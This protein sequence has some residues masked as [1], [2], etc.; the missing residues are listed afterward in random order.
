MH[1]KYDYIKKSN[2][3]VYCNTIRGRFQSDHDYFRFYDNNNKI[4]TYILSIKL[5][6]KGTASAM[7]SLP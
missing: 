1:V 5:N 2:K 4:L 3:Y 7:H 6:H